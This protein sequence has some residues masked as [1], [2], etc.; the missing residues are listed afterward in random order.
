MAGPGYG[1][2]VNRHYGGFDLAGRIGDML[3]RSGRDRD[4]PTRDDLAAFDEF[5]TGG[6]ESTRALARLAGLRPGMRVLD[7]GSGVGG[8]ARTLAAE[9]GVRV[10]GLDLTREF[11][12]AAA[13]LT[14]LTGLT[15]RVS[16]QQGDALALPYGDERFDVVWSQNTIMNIPDKARL[17]RGVHRVLT[18]GGAFALEAALAGPEGA[19]R[20]PTFWA[21]SAALSFLD[22]PEVTRALLARAGLVV[23]LWEDVTAENI[24]QARRRAA[25]Q[26]ER[27]PQSLGRDVIVRDDVP[28]KIANSLRNAVERR[29]V[30]VRAVCRRP[31]G[32]GAGRDTGSDG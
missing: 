11:C 10:L 12:R 28:L 24:A 21:S 18:P 1:K 9:F 7:V 15:D 3:A 32:M 23:E 14:R 5:H 20:Y 8:P 19:V 29:I 17:F 31:R 16:F 25:A 4:A 26:S 22:T 27:G 13:L 2:A 6:R 30:A